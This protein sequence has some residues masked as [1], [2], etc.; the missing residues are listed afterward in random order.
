ME[1]VPKSEIIKENCTFFFEIPRIC[2]LSL[3]KQHINTKRYLRKGRRQQSAEEKIKVEEKRRKR[4]RGRRGKGEGEGKGKGEI[5][6]RLSRAYVRAHSNR[7]IIFLLSQVSHDGGKFDRKARKLGE[8]EEKT[9]RKNVLFSMVQS[10][11][12][13]IT[14]SV[15]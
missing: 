3:A 8:I 15:C 1:I 14:S 5:S 6:V 12:W 9:T 13:T 4:G 11:F 7:N 2:N 10:P